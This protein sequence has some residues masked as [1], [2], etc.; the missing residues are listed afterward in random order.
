[1]KKQRRE[2]TSNILLNAHLCNF[3]RQPMTVPVRKLPCWHM[4]IHGYV[5]G[6]MRRCR[7]AMTVASSMGFEGSMYWVADE[8]GWEGE[9]TWCKGM[10]WERR[11]C[12]LYARALAKGKGGEGKGKEEG[13]MRRVQ[14]N[15]VSE[16]S[17]G[18]S[19][20]TARRLSFSIKGKLI[21][22]G[23]PTSISQVRRRRKESKGAKLS[24]GTLLERMNGEGERCG[25]LGRDLI[26]RDRLR[27]G[28][29]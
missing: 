1:M 26:G 16:G 5:S 20:M 7:A 10:E 28:Q 24:R 17:W 25:W 18:A 9:Q 13:G 8:D 14:T 12:W 6:F 19:Q 3:L 4:T 11:N 15:K 22:V 23:W 21:S 27:R 2:L 29:S